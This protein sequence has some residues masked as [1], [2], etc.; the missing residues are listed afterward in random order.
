MS[1]A[2]FKKGFYPLYLK[3]YK[4]LHFSMSAILD[5]KLRPSWAN[6]QMGPYRFEIG[7][8]K[9][10]YKLMSCFYHSFEQSH[11]LCA[12]TNRFPTKSLKIMNMAAILDSKIFTNVINKCL[13]Y[14]YCI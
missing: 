10:S 7:I 3:S 13:D 4:N 11:N 8:P 5:C 6:S 14:Q 2:T 1:V 12:M 9:L